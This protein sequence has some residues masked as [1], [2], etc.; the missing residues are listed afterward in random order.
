MTLQQL[1]QQQQTL[2]NLIANV[3]G[4]NNVRKWVDELLVVEAKI[5]EIEAAMVAAIEVIFNDGDFEGLTQ[6]WVLLVGGQ[7]VERF[8]TRA[9]CDRF[10][11]GKGLVA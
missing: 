6:P 5:E 4:K 10:L 1:K 3:G 8:A 11:A 2:L 9:K 7:E